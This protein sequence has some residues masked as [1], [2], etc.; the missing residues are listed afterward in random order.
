MGLP[1]SVG[2]ASANIIALDKYLQ[3]RLPGSIWLGQGKGEP[4]WVKN[5][6]G[7]W[8]DLNKEHSSGNAQDFIIVPHVGMVPTSAQ[9]KTAWRLINWFIKNARAINLRWI[10]FG[11]DQDG[12]AWSWNPAR[13]TWKRLYTGGV[14]EAHTDH[15]HVYLGGGDQDFSAIDNS[16]L[17]GGDSEEDEVNIEQLHAELNNNEM[18][19]EL[20]SRTGQVATKLGEATAL[21]DVTAQ[22]TGMVVNEIQALTG[23]IRQLVDE[24]RRSGS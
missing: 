17:S 21:I 24:L 18:I 5:K 8:V 10:I 23:V 22:R 1:N 15:I 12:W 4:N 9:L 13:G 11:K 14:S 19:S 2:N 16:P 7:E 6:N 3:P 20:T